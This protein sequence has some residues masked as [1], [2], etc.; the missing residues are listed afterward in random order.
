MSM[1]INRQTYGD[2]A[3][4]E[5]LRCVATK[6]A[7][8]GTDHWDLVE[9]VE[10]ENASNGLAIVIPCTEVIAEPFADLCAGT[11]KG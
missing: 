9:G 7:H 1:G 11:G 6:A 2:P 3:G 10:S 4:A 8:I 5:L